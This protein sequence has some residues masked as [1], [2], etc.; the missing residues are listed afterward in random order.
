MYRKEV[1]ATAG[2][3]FTRRNED[4]AAESK[5]ANRESSYEAEERFRARYPLAV[6]ARKL[7]DRHIADDVDAMY[8]TTSPERYHERRAIYDELAREYDE[9]SGR[10]SRRRRR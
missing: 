10:R 5:V 3:E 8:R 9:R 2:I 7:D 6:R 1:S 4:L